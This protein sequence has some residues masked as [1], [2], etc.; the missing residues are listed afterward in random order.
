VLGSASGTSKERPETMLNRPYTSA[1]VTAAT[2]GRIANTRLSATEIRPVYPSSARW[3]AVC[4]L[5][6]A[7][8]ISK[9][10]MMNAHTATRRRA[11]AP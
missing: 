6:K 7:R 2:S 8:Y 9:K 10:S 11:R 3:P 4:P 5:P 1:I